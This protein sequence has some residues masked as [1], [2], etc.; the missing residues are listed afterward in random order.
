VRIVVV[1]KSRMDTLGST[2]FEEAA[3]PLVG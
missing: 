1:R 2:L 3:T